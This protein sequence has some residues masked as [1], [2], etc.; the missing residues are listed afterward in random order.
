[1]LDK[2]RV[3]AEVA[4]RNGI[5][6]E[7]ND[8]IFAVVTIM[9]LALEESVGALHEKLQA[10]S[11]ECTARVQMIECEAR[12]RL[13]QDVKECAAA[14]RGELQAD[15]ISANRQTRKLVTEVKEAYERPTITIWGSVGVLCALALFLSG[16]WYGQLTAVR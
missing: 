2:Q 12:K 1:M 15:I 10:S 6:I 7:S 14:I 8:P 4:A 16:V 5:R 3:I 11:A 13:V 9:Q